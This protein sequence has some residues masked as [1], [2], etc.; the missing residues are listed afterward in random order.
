M[1]LTSKID[2]EIEIFNFEIFNKIIS[3]WIQL[4]IENIWVEK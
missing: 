1:L 2:S 4:K 3:K